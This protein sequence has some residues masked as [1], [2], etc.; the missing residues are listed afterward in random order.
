[1]TV[2]QAL[3]GICAL[4]AAGLCLS[5]IDVEDITISASDGQVKVGKY[6]T[7]LGFPTTKRQ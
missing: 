5:S 2:D 7:L 4:R 3:S 1:M 6:R